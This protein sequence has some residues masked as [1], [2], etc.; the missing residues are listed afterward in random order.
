MALPDELDFV[1]KPQATPTRMNEAMEYIV[2]RLRALE[3]VTPDFIAAID[4]LKAVGLERLTEALVPIFEEAQSIGDAL[5]A[6]GD[7]WLA[8]DL[9]GEM[10][11]NV[12]AALRG[13]VDEEFDTLDKMA[14][15]LASWR[16][17]YLGP[18]ATAP[19]TGLN[20]VPLVAG[21]LYYDTAISRMRVYNGALWQDAGSV[22]QGILSRQAFTAVGG[23]TSVTVPG[24]YDPGNIIVSVNGLVMSPADVV[25]TS[26]TAIGLVGALVAGD[27]VSWT[28]FATV[29]A[30]NVYTKSEVDDLLDEMLALAAA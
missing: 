6:I 5:Q 19:T 25:V 7:Q 4:Q 18:S 13:G 15:A 3:A 30:V 10:E 16:A 12:L 27:E 21:M 20:G 22:V 1:V 9:P 17:L 2:A 23:E 26:G 8:E 28:K 29:T 11:A 14:D 24:G